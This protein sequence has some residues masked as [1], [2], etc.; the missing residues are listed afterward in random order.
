[1]I[2]NILIQT[3]NSTNIL[4]A[5]LLRSHFETYNFLWYAKEDSYIYKADIHS[6]YG[7]CN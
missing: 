3:I 6:L 5:E 4:K 1:M 7:G 2:E